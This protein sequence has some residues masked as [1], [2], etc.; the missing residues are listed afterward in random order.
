MVICTGDLRRI[1]NSSK[2]TYID[3]FVVFSTSVLSSLLH[4]DY[5]ALSSAVVNDTCLEKV[6]PPTAHLHEITPN[7]QKKIVDNS[8]R[9]LIFF[10]IVLKFA[11]YLHG[12]PAND[13]TER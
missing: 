7:I 1:Q 5:A 9:K 12:N 13:K 8:G 4:F 11:I 3:F 6:A 2:R 10:Q